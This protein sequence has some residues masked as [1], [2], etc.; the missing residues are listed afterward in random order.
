MSCGSPVPRVSSGPIR[1]AAD[2]AGS[3]ATRPPMGASVGSPRE[4]ASWRDG[5]STKWV[6]AV[7]S[8]VPARV[9][10]W[11]SRCSA[12][13]RV[14]AAWR[15]RAPFVRSYCVFVRSYCVDEDRVGVEPEVL[16]GV[17]VAPDVGG[18]PVRVD[19][20]AEQ[21]GLASLA[22]RPRPA[23]PMTRRT[24]T[25]PRRR[26]PGARPVRAGRSGHRSH[27]RPGRRARPRPSRG[28]TA[29]G[30]AVPAGCGGLGGG[31]RAPRRSRSPAWS[32]R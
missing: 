27:R 19:R 29:P 17:G 2:L 23:R 10:S 26:A 25:P 22:H 28:H 14:C 31:R 1:T 18:R 16:P 11:W 4:M 5:E 3:A 13:W 20:G 12:S 21:T 9:T 24:G 6:Q 30:S 8:R 15:R 32:S 7:T